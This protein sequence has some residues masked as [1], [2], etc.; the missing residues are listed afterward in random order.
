MLHL[1]RAE[2]ADGLVAMLAEL[3]A[4]PL[5]DPLAAELV[6]VPTRGVERWLTQQLSRHLGASPGRHDGVCANVECPFPGTIIGA[7][8]AVAGGVDPRTDPWSPARSVWPLLEVVAESLDEGWLE[9]LRTHLAHSGPDG[10]VRRF[11]SVRHIADLYDRYSVHRPQMLRA[12]LDGQRDHPADQWQPELWRRLRRRIGTPSP[13][14]RLTD[15]VARLADQPDLLDLPPRLSL[16]GLTRLPASYL[17]V[18]DVVAAQRDVHLFL[19][20]PS[21]VL[22]ERVA[23]V[24]TGPTR[25]RARADDPSTAVTENPLLASWGRD[26]REMQ[27]VIGG[28]GGRRIDHHRPIEGGVDDLLHRLQDDIR[29]DRRPP[30]LPA[31]GRADDRVPLGPDDRSLQV[32]ACHGRSRQVEVVRD[33]VLHLLAEDPTLEPRDVIVMCPDIETYAPLVQATFASDDPDEPAPR[34]LPDLRVRLADR[35]LRQTNPVLGVVAELLELST[36]R[37]TASEVLDLAGREPVRRRFGLDDDELARIEEWVVGAGVRWGLDAEHRAPFKLGQLDANTWHAG[38]DRAL[39]GVTMAEVGPRL[40]EGIVPLDDMDSGDIDLVGRL[41]ELVDRLGEAVAAFGTTQPV[42]AWARAISAV[43]DAFTAPAEAD[44]WQRVQLQRLLDDLVAEST[45]DGRVSPVELGP[46]DVRS[47]IG[48]RLRGRPTRANFRTGN[49]TICTLVPMR[50]VPHRVVCLLGLDDGVFPRPVERDGDDLIAANP[51]VGDNDPRAEDRQLLLDA[52]LSATDRVVITY[53]ARDERSNLPRPPAVPLGELLDVIDRTVVAADGRR[54]RDHLTI[55]H[56][57]HPFDVRNFTP[58]ALVP[59]GPWSF[60]QVNLEGARALTRPARPAGP[61]LDGPL[62]P[63]EVG[64]IELE[65]LEGFVRH[66]VRAFLRYRLGISLGQRSR[67][68]D[69]TLPIELDGLRRWAVA[70]RMLAARLAGAPAADVA[71]VER[72]RGHLPPGRLADPILAGITPAVDD[73][74]AAA[75][76]EGEPGSRDVNVALGDGR[77][78]VGTVAGLRG[79]QLHSVTYSTLGPRQRLVAWVR[80]LALTAAWPDTAWQAVTIGRGR[81]VRGRDAVVVATVGP[82]GDDADERRARALGHLGPLLELFG[83]GMAEPLP[84]YTATSAAWVGA[85]GPPGGAELAVKAWTSAY[86][87]PRED[88]EPEHRL[89]LGDPVPF[90][91]M[92]ARAGDLRPDELADGRA[93]PGAGRF[94]HYARRLWDGLLAGERLEER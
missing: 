7:A 68:V 72:A 21:P 62:P 77:S 10:E 69:D 9:P 46:A 50:S 84:L 90:E 37:L 74:V 78:V 20:H 36:S 51:E 80:L 92:V 29:A 18:L 57:L 53:T 66:P 55:R 33:A 71:A 12:W 82:L 3:L 75:R 44:T 17:D 4:D 94:D 1:H 19:L 65:R 58:G 23:A 63:L 47:L 15:A 67:D 30:G 79:R 28:G 38:L 42:D 27:L 34:A 14:E 85:T 31:P 39:L 73:L 60:D 89:V 5:E 56:P 54:A 81:R 83:R 59:S 48:D 43:A 45:T 26:A 35:S 2:R 91:E 11:A 41:A 86:E 87:R 52:L 88:A 76:F 6:A 93:A 22:W 32:H 16:F 49:L 64:P 61:W 8:L 24:A 13:A 40:F 25:G 70:E